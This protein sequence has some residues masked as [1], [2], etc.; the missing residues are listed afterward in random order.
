VNKLKL[1]SKEEK[2][3]KRISKLSNFNNNKISSN[4][5]LMPNKQ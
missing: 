2:M 1:R 4:K 5:P 3:K